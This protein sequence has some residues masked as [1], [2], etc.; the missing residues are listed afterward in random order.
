MTRNP[1]SPRRS[2]WHPGGSPRRRAGAVAIVVL[3]AAV[4]LAAA[5]PPEAGRDPLPR[6]P[7]GFAVTP[8]ADVGGILTSLDWAD[9][10][11]YATDF[12]AGTVVRI[13]D[14]TG[15]GLASTPPATFAEGF[16][17]P[18]G[19]LA[20]GDGTVFVTDAEARRDGPFGQRSYGRVWRVQ[21]TDGDGTADVQEVV[22]RDLPQGRHNT[23]DLVLGP[24]GMLY[25][26]NGNSTD[27]GIDGGDPEVTPWS[28]SVV[29]ISPDATDVSVADLDPAEHLVAT[30]MRNLFDL[31]FSPVDPTLLHIPTNGID[32]ARPGTTGGDPGEELEA[33]DDLL[34]VTDVD[35]TRTV[36]T[37]DGSV[38]TEPVIDHFGFPS[39]L[40]N[41]AR[42]GDLQPYDSPNPEVIDAFGACPTATVPR[43]VASFGLHV[44]ANGLAFQ[45]T[46]AW[47]E[48][49]RD[50]LFVAEF[51]NFFGEEVVGHRVVHVEL[52][53]GGRTVERQSE[54]LSGA[55]PLDVT[56]GPGTD[57]E[58]MYVGDF[59]GTIYRVD[60]AADVPDTV[61][62]SIDAFQFAPAVVVVAEGMTVRWTNQETLGIG[63][64]VDGV[65]HA[66][67]E[68]AT[69]EGGQIDSPGA[70]PVGD[71]YEVRFET[72]GTY[73]YTCT[74]NQLH[75]AVMHGQVVVLPAGS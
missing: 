9:G 26:T 39:C 13:E 45:T 71:T 11:L 42:Q 56:F 33:S 38:T 64:T 27:D 57:G 44:S 62:V 53:P 48:D 7:P 31:A 66:D 18:L 8:Y 14:P 68:G 35:D 43:P 20:V 74:F 59:S 50:D 72:P 65:A 24:D 23:N 28:G 73:N 69:G 70:L 54:F 3:V 2:P 40:Y 49:H 1:H 4:V 47:G 16:R 37:P 21:D 5:A 75:T 63:H 22:L 19:V 17:N 12:A 10:T 29:R 25:V 55:A 30:G 51:G 61:D 32:D 52:D 6:V 67:A 36:T 60:Q 15:Q 34:Y 58:A 46:D 41:T